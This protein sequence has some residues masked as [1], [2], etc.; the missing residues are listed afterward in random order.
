M[1]QIIQ[2]LPFK[3]IEV[4]YSLDCERT[5]K[6]HPTGNLRGKKSHR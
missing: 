4:T 5:L 6:P 2:E 3:V 1:D